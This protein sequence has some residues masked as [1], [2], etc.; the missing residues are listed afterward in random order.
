MSPSPKKSP[1][2]A[3]F[4]L[5]GTIVVASSLLLAK[6]LQSR[7]DSGEGYPAYSS[8]RT[9]P[10][11]TRVLFDSLESLPN[12][13]TTRNFL[14]LKKL[15]SPQNKTLI[16][17]GLSQSEF[18]YSSFDSSTLLNFAQN[19]GRIIIALHST[20]ETTKRDK[21]TSTP[22]SSL[23]KSN[24]PL[25][26]AFQ[27]NAFA[28]PKKDRSAKGH[29]PLSLTTS[30][31]DLPLWHS[32]LYFEPSL[33]DHSDSHPSTTSTEPIGEEPSFNSSAESNNSQNSTPKPS[34]W[35][36]LASIQSHP[37]L[38]ERTLGKGSIVLCSDRFFLSNEA[39]WSK[40]SLSFLS[41]LVGNSN[42]VIF[43]ETFIQVGIGDADGIMTL[44][45]RYQMHGLF[46]GGIL[47]F[48][49]ACWRNASS[50]IPPNLNSDLGIWQDNAVAGQGS[51]SGLEGLLRR[52]IKPIQLLR[53][54]FASWQK[55][56]AASR[57]ISQDRLAK[58]EAA[59]NACNHPSDIPKTYE[60]VSQTLHS[61]S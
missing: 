21:S 13:Q 35:K 17:C 2:I 24:R 55:S 50:L 49:L 7:F 47:L 38:L 10:L 15:T 22:V 39:L 32:N 9:D 37:V 48:L 8:L 16:L 30:F 1:R 31:T 40:P 20:E 44:A 29:T 33:P 58:A 45:R 46:L 6:I 54:C 14:P 43:D 4:L 5:L 41:W 11:G 60:T 12:I 25:S 19:G 36:T 23:K 18:S 27:V 57:R 59:I 51:T 26:E 3:Q 52:G 42:T 61:K 34:P 28:L 53:I 56:K